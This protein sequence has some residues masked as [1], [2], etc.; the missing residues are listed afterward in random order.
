MF[1]YRSMLSLWGCFAGGMLFCHGPCCRLVLENVA[2][3]DCT[4]VVS[5]GAHAT[6]RNTT[7]TMTHSRSA[8]EFRHHAVLVTG[9]GSSLSAE[10]LAVETNRGIAVE[11]GGAVTAVR[12]HVNRA[13]DLIEL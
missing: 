4:L 8:P 2:L 5:G 3:Y 10:D 1:T 13:P 9:A 6:V 7:A 12:T 11:D